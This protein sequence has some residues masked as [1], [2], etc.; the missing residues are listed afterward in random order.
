MNVGNNK[1]MSIPR[2]KFFILSIIL[3][4]VIVI[5]VVII[6]FV[7]NDRE[8]NIP[9]GE[10]SDLMFEKLK[11][12]HPE[13]SVEQLNFYRETAI[14]D[15]GATSGC[16]GRS[17]EID[18]IASVS[19]LK[20]DEKLCYTVGHKE[21]EI[22]EEHKKPQKECVSAILNQS[23]E[24]K[25]NKCFSLFGDDFINCFN[26]ILQMYDAKEECSVLSL[27]TTRE[28]C[29]S[30]F[31]FNVA[32]SQYERG[33]CAVIK[34]EKIKQYCLDNIIDK[35][36]DSDGDGLMDLDEINIYK[37]DP[38]DSDTDGDGYQDGNEVKNGFNPLGPGKLFK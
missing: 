15:Q 2:N 9:V 4:F 14:Q 13:F 21:N 24:E 28:I 6:F 25:F 8:E 3:L 20:N 34:D 31:D 18:C 19:F 17:D 30:I 16:R 26:A 27:E 5:F 33:M 12:N 36:Q 23:G 29:E 11:N 7:N 1:I 35:L 32:F 10:K 37:T 22:E 38:K